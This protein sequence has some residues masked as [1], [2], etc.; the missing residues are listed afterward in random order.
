MKLF[1]ALKRFW[2]LVLV[3]AIIILIILVMSA[4]NGHQQGVDLQKKTDKGDKSQPFTEKQLEAGN[5]A[6]QDGIKI[7]DPQNDYFKF[8]LH[9][10]QPDGRPDNDNPYP[11]NYTDLRSLSIGA[12]QDYLYVKFQFW[13]EFPEKSPYY[14][15]DLIWSVGGKIEDFNFTNSEGKQDSAE[16]GDSVWFV[17]NN[18]K[19]EISPVEQPSIG[20]LSLISP[21]GKDEKMEM[22]YKTWNGSGMI[23]GGPGYDY[24]IG[25]YPL[26]LFGIKLGDNVTFSASTETGSTVY[27][28]VCIDF[29]LGKE[30]YLG[31]STIKYKLGDNKYEIIKPPSDI[32][33]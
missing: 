32:M 1:P 24:L 15:G 26:R 9:H 25:A 16:L 27:H 12:D 13:G 6:L 18:E 31:G 17:G 21:T 30:G 8:P 28:H 22:V 10:F 23:A 2:L 4:Y 14:N 29:I 19:G 20:Q 33:G 3:L 11:L 7:D 5:L